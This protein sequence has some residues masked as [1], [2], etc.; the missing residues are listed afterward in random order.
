ML[1]IS[2]ELRLRRSEARLEGGSRV[3][4]PPD[5]RR[6]WL[7]GRWETPGN[8]IQLA[9]MAC[10]RGR[11]RKTV[12]GRTVVYKQGHVGVGE[13]AGRLSGGRVGGHDDD[14]R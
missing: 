10:S 8:Q 9:S 5:G 6:V 13:N 1:E 3:G 11:N 14:G 12:C 7:G 4:E 2:E